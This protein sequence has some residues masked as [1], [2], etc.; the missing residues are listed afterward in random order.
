[1]S[2]NK[3]E[4]TI[5][6]TTGL[7]LQ[8]RPEPFSSVSAACQ[9]C[10]HGFRLLSCIPHTNPA[11]H[12]KAGFK[13]AESL[14]KDGEKRFFSIL[15]CWRN[16]FLPQCNAWREKAIVPTQESKLIVDNESLGNIKIQKLIER[17]ILVT[18]LCV[19]DK[20]WHR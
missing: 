2:G 20:L 17:L 15:C 5:I 8:E 19:I 4:Q 11:Y 18:F 10:Y 12:F 1:M 9:S 13:F 3:L 6:I 14:K 7:Q 16:T